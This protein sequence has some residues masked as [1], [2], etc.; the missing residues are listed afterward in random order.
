MLARLTFNIRK[1]FCAK[2]Y[3][4]KLSICILLLLSFILLHSANLQAQTARIF[5]QGI[6]QP[7]GAKI[8]ICKNSSLIFIDTS[9]S[10][11]SRNWIFKSG[12][13]ITSVAR[14]VAVLFDSC[15]TDTVFLTA[16]G[17]SN[18][19]CYFIIEVIQ[20]P[21]ASLDTLNATSS[22]NFDPTQHI[23]RNCGA[24]RLS[25]AFNF[26]I[27]N[28]SST[29][30]VNTGYSIN[31]GD[32]N[33]TV[34]ASSFSSTNHPYAGM[35]HYT[36]IINAFNAGCSTQKSYNF[37]NGNTPAGSLSTIAGT[38]DCIPYTLNWPVDTF[39]TNQNT[40]GTRYRF[41]VNDS[42]AVQIFTQST[43]PA[44]ITHHFT[45]SSCNFPTANSFT[46]NLD[47][48]N[49]CGTNPTSPGIV[50]PAQKPIAAISFSSDSIVC[51][52][53][54]ITISNISSG[55][56][57]NGPICVTIFNKNWNIK[58]TT[59]FLIISGTLAPGGTSVYGSNNINVTF[60][61]PG[62]YT[63]KLKISKPGSLPPA[64]R[65]KEDSVEKNICIQP[66]PIP[67][68]AFVQT[69]LNGCVSNSIGITNTSNTLQSCGVTNYKWMIFD[70][71]Q[72]A[73]ALLLSGARF[74]Y[75]SNTDSNSIHPVITFLQKGLYRIRLQISNN[76]AGIYF[77]DTLI[78]IKDK[79]VVHF[80]ADRIYCDT[81][82]I[83]FDQNTNHTL[84]LDS[85]YGIFTGFNWAIIPGTVI[86]S[87]GN[88]ASRY[89]TVIF[90][91]IGIVPVTYTVILRATNGCGISIADTQLITIKPKPLINVFSSATTF[92]SGDTTQIMVSSN[93]PSG[94]SYTWRSYASDTTV[95]GF[96]N[97]LTGIASPWQQTIYNTGNNIARVT[98][99]IIA[100][101]SYTGCTSDSQTV[102]VNI[103]PVVKVHAANAIV[104]SG[105][106]T[107]I[108]LSSNV[109]NAV[110]TWAASLYSG[111]ATGYSSQFT[112]VNGPL[113]QVVYNTTMLPAIVRY[114]I[115][116]RSNTCY[117]T[118][119]IIYVTIEPVPAITNTILTQRLCAGDTA[120]FIPAYNI[121][122]ASIS[123]TSSLLSGYAS[124]FVNGNNN[125]LQRI[126][127]NGNIASVI[128]YRITPVGTSIANC[129]GIPVNFEVSSYPK[130]QAAFTR[131]PSDSGCSPLT[132][133]YIN[134]SDPKNGESLNSMKFL[135][136]ITGLPD[137]S[138]KNITE[139]FTNSG[140]IDSITNI[141]L[142]AC[143]QWGCKDTF[144]TQ[145]KV[146]PFPKSDF[147]S[148][149]FSACAPFTINSSV[150]SL[151]QYAIANS[152]YIWQILNSLQMALNTTTGIIAPAHTLILPND[153]VYYR[154]ITS[155]NKGCKPDTLLHLFRTVSNISADFTAVDSIACSGNTVSFN[156]TSTPSAGLSY[157]W[158]FGNSLMVSN[159]KN[160]VYSFYNQGIND[161]LIIIKLIIQATGNGCTD[162]ISKSIVIKPLPKPD[163]NLS[164]SILCWP[165]KL[166]VVNNS[167]LI[168]IVNPISFKWSVIQ[169]GAIINNDTTN[170]QAL[171]S[172]S[173]NRSGMA[174]IYNIKLVN[175]SAYGCKD[176]VQKTLRIPSRP[177][178][179]FNFG[180]DSAC[181]NVLIN[182]S[183]TTLFGYNYNWFSPKVGPAITN[184]T[185]T[186]TSILFPEHKGMIDSLYPI[187]LIAVS[188]ESCRD[189]LNKTFRTFP[190]PVASFITDKDTGCAPL[191]IQFQN[192]TQIK[193][194]GT[195]LW[196]F[197]N[198]I[199]LVNNVS[200]FNRTFSGASNSDTTYLIRLIATSANGCRDTL[201]K[202]IH[203]NKIVSAIIELEDTLICA[204]LLSPTQVK[205][206]NQSTGQADAYF[207]N[208]GDGSFLITDKDTT[209]YHTYNTAGNYR[210]VMKA[211]NACGVSFDTAYFTIQLPPVVNFTKSDTA[212]CS[213]LMVRFSNQSLH[214]SNTTLTWTFGDGQTSTSFNPSRITYFQSTNTDTTYYVQ[215][216][217]TNYCGTSIKKDSISVFPEPT[218]A[219]ITDIDSGCS[220]ILI[221]L[222]NQTT[223]KPQNIKWDFGNGDSS[224][225]FS[226]LQNPLRYTTVDTTVIYKITLIADNK[227]GLD[228]AVKYI[229]ILPNTVHSF[230]TT[231]VN[232]GCQNLTVS[233]SDKSIGGNNV[234]W[235]FGDN[236]TSAA[237]NPVHT[238]T[239]SGNFTAYQYVNN[240]CSYDTSCIKITVHAKPIFIIQKGSGNNC[241]NTPFKFSSILLDSGSIIWQFGDGVGS[242][243]YNPLHVYT[244][245]GKKFITATIISGL[246]NCSA[247]L[248][249]SVQV[250][251]LPVVSI[252][253]D[254]WKDCLYHAFNL[255][256]RSDGNYYY[257]WSFGDSNLAV[258]QQVNH[259]FDKPGTYTLKL[260]ATSVNGC[261]DSV[262]GILHTWPV[263][264]A[265]F[266]YT[267][268][269]TC[270]GPALV[271]FTNRSSDAEA[272][273]WNFSNGNSTNQTH[274]SQM[275][276]VVGKYWIQ[277][278]SKN[279]YYC[280]DTIEHDFTIF[281]KPLPD[282]NFDLSSGCSPHTVKFS[283]KS[284]FI[285]KY[286]WY[287]GD[288]DTSTAEEP[289]HTYLKDG[290]F[291]VKLLGY[292]GI[293]C[294]DSLT[295]TNKITVYPKPKPKF[296]AEVDNSAK[297]YRMVK[298]TSQSI[299]GKYYQWN[300]G[301]GW[302]NGGEATYH[303]YGETDSGWQVVQLKVYSDMLC[304]SYYVDS[305]YIP[306]YW[307]GLFVPNAFT[308]EYGSDAVRVFRPVGKELKSYHLR[309]FNKWGELLWETADLLN[310]EPVT[311]WDG[312][313]LNGN[314]CM[315]GTY[316][317][318]IEAVFTDGTTWEGM[319]YRGKKNTRANVTL[320]K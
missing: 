236:G 157:H 70:T 138:L 158:Q 78:I 123:Y 300:L 44:F 37:F 217:I 299:L 75:T 51:S 198:G 11:T 190:K 57:F 14:L 315:Q 264:K 65:C 316:V 141:R 26:Y 310:G 188:M 237:K 117:S 32:G 7:N 234:S 42:S 59:G 142:I 52:N 232:N 3:Y 4:N 80:P 91:G 241:V 317:W 222:Q 263:P 47:V 109:N 116:A 226:P 144:Q 167:G 153:T 23:F 41:Y 255:T 113:N 318:A 240:N 27:A 286:L 173:D 252:Q 166:T 15:G 279:A 22:A 174:K 231:S 183:N 130:P 296:I 152:T 195:Y 228:T 247:T 56:Y 63:V 249:D 93:M 13:P 16:N 48:T 301:S 82:L 312:Y 28:A 92:C 169:N 102:V 31:W 254:T 50:R 175:R 129:A 140:F 282:F 274:V 95:S 77:K 287:F 269:D 235:N 182:V 33:N 86:Y 125:I 66:T 278:I 88:N 104:C 155:N 58:P 292:A 266:E 17:L 250:Y 212:G 84:L 72:T 134:T 204:N 43:L 268:Q 131:T 202:P 245:A 213:P 259:K 319:E 191:N 137:D 39:N 60:T 139:R 146:F 314:P 210:I 150:I 55:N 251:P 24:S 163:F 203:T 216:M 267:P 239:R 99:K 225:L 20:K 67:S 151:Q 200:Q 62:I 246:N 25:P 136:S 124:G 189:T 5:A 253:T 272:Y 133:N 54:S 45:R 132:V 273:T 21:D 307:K 34:L 115:K 12:F 156:N 229:T 100:L 74:V 36:I 306:G 277:L 313:D 128:R 96:S 185:N 260:Q 205:I 2:P 46:I 297:P 201:V 209:M 64:S 83:A 220:P 98:Y 147:T 230:I 298:L 120:R 61:T 244:D 149:C 76:C 68:F 49:P 97:Q 187:R 199:S 18:H 154:L 265:A 111:T 160:P 73:P 257:A 284:K 258:G 30:S 162:S 206:A 261:A 1:L 114:A 6:I 238:Y 122:T 303:R 35:G 89:P 192:T 87:K 126:V 178:S 211:M 294:L 196:V 103:Y 302:I 164:D 320:I 276:S 127:N 8:H 172:F 291:H 293:N 221:R 165:S 233:F 148:V 118:D 275:Y 295:G 90:P 168:P 218:A 19:T 159:N 193:N 29:A 180:S 10:S 106:G 227:C 248:T 197:G 112:T 285:K 281:S 121:S 71:S 171:I 40:P 143:T 224:A 271:K 280:T 170:T 219:F 181:G 223:G 119:S 194:P 262:I 290:D 81:Q 308:P 242:A 108:S 107:N 38:S 177:I 53:N 69:P 184:S 176:S 305:V 110:Y 214:T 9:L 186:H 94:I 79:P 207:W 145:A 311:A 288:G 161:T 304:E 208:F 283:N 179:G 85:S 105:N 270:N 135:W 101:Q 289:V 243:F 215:L 256:A 309:I